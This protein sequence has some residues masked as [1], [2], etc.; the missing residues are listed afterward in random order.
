M[1]EKHVRDVIARV[2]AARAKKQRRALERALAKAAKAPEP[3]VE[4][5][6]EPKAD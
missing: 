2:K 4:K 1:A 5:A 6:P 3:V